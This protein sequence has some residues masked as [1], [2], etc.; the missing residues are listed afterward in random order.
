MSDNENGVLKVTLGGEEHEVVL[1]QQW[2]VRRELV[3]GCVRN[4][5][6]G[7]AAVVGACVPSLKLKA[8]YA[9]HHCEPVAYGG[10]VWEELSMRGIGDG[11]IVE[12]S[13]AIFN[14]LREL[15]FPSAEEVEGAED[16]S[17]ASE[18][19]PTSPPSE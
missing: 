14:A 19:T 16:F 10:A 1:P 3:L 9:G 13:V 18:A 4:S 11:E 2:A 5:L 7:G 6:R 17:S 12:Q 8:S 15:A